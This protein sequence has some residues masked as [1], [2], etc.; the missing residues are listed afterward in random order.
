MFACWIVIFFWFETIVRAGSYLECG[1]VYWI[2]LIGV[3]GVG[4]RGGAEG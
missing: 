3:V 1:C 4:G 2:I